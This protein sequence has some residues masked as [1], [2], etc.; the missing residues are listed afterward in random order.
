MSKL[1]WGMI[2]LAVVAALSVI[3]ILDQF[4]PAFILP[5]ALA[6]L[7]LYIIRIDR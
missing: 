3:L 5:F 6:L 4:I 1:F 2:I 7:A